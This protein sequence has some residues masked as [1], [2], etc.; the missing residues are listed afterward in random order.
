MCSAVAIETPSISYS[1]IKGEEKP[2][3]GAIPACGDDYNIA[4]QSNAIVLKGV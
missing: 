3:S 4:R 2:F 1:S